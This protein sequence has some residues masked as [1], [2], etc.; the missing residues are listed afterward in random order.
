MCVLF[1]G[2]IA[3]GNHR[4]LGTLRVPKM[5]HLTHDQL[6]ALGPQKTVSELIPYVVQAGLESV[7]HAPSVSAL[8]VCTRDLT[9]CVTC[10]GAD[11]EASLQRATQLDAEFRWCKRSLF[12]TTTSF[13]IRWQGPI[14]QLKGFALDLQC[15]FAGGAFQAFSILQRS[16]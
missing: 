12:A 7:L 1:S 3:A 10:P 14:V 2:H 4:P 6:Q 5:R 13:C 11:S 15:L 9:I 16:C 8:S